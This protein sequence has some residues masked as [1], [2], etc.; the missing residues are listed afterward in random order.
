MTCI[1]GLVENGTVYLGGDSAGV[2]GSLHLTVRADPKVF[3]NGPCLIG[4]TSSFRMGQL[5]RYKLEPPLC[6]PATDPLE[7][8]AT[9]FVDAVRGTLKAGGMASKEND[10]EQGGAFL[11]GYR[12]RLFTIHEDYQVGE[13][14]VPY[15]AVGC[16]APYA[17]GALFAAPPTVTPDVRL[18]V[19]LEAAEQF[20]A[21]VRRPFVFEALP[22]LAVP[23]EES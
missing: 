21:G 5:L 16:G 17:L 4:Y 3:R 18:R 10:V 15:A 23:S 12:G 8:L 1:V 2:N 22:A 20:S 19:A 7:Y 11:V 6:A 14:T 9:S 13:S